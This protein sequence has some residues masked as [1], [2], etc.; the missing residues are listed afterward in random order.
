MD[1][2]LKLVTAYI[3]GGLLGLL[4]LFVFNIVP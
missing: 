1:I 2:V 4:S 3:L